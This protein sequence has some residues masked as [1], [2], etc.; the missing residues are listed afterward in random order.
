MIGIGCFLR[1]SDQAFE[2]Q[3]FCSYGFNLMYI[4]D[5]ICA[6]ANAAC[7]NLIR[8]RKFKSI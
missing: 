6:V 2:T 4:L 5:E 8:A 7:H 3:T 1:Y